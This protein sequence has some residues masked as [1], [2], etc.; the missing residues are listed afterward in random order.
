M[1]ARTAAYEGREVSWEE[2]NQSKEVWDAKIDL[3]RLR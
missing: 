3:N 2:L 1:M